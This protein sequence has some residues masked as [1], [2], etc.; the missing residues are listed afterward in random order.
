MNELLASVHESIRK[1]LDQ[2]D[3]PEFVIE[4][5]S[6]STRYGTSR[7]LWLRNQTGNRTGDR[8]WRDKDFISL[9]SWAE[10][11][12]A[13]EADIEEAAFRILPQLGFHRTDYI[14][15]Y[16]GNNLNSL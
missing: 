10:P 15:E 8:N 14:I 7:T 13:L 11:G 2:A 4:E 16:Q 1:E 6:C 12:Q 3:K 5:G 9:V